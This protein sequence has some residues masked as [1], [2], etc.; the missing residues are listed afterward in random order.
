MRITYSKSADAAYVY[1]IDEIKKGEVKTI[2]PCD[3][4]KEEGV[5]GEI[6]LDFDKEDKLLG[7]EILDAS[8]KLPQEVLDK[9][10]EI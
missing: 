4:S 10:E 1:L 7:I 8:R 3:P 5:N 2:Y 9:A 6:N